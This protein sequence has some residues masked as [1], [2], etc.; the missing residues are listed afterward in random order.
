MKTLVLLFLL[1][2]GPAAFGDDNLLQNGDFSD[3]ISHWNG[4]C[5][6]PD[7]ASVDL[8]SKP[9]SGVVV[10]LRPGEWTK[11]SQ[12]FDGPSGNYLVTITFTISPGATFS[13]KPEDFLN[14]PAQIGIRRNGFDADPGDWV[15]ILDSVG[16]R[17]L[18]SW[19]TG[20]NL[21]TSDV[22]TLTHTFHVDSR[23]SGLKGFYL[24]FPPGDGIINLQS[25]MVVPTS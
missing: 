12:D 18:M 8:S 22:Q 11:I 4:E 1:A 23:F 25:I 17:R 20:P 7:S 19:K 21:N 6:S 16:A 9:A 3:G 14:I 5:H 24:G 15:V 2:A 10:K 13:N